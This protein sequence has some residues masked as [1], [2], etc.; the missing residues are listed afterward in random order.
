MT[1]SNAEDLRKLVEEF[2]DKERMVKRMLA[3]EDV[4][5]RVYQIVMA[6]LRQ[7]R[8]SLVLVENVCRLLEGL[9]KEG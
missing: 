2:P 5:L 4:S 1:N 3:E 7:Q 6:I 9:E 8:A